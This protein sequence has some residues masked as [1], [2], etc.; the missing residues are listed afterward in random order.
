[1]LQRRTKVQHATTRRGFGRALAVATKEATDKVKHFKV[2]LLQGLAPALLTTPGLAA[3][4]KAPPQADSLRG[5]F[6]LVRNS[7]QKILTRLNS[8]K[9]HCAHTQHEF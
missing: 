9:S 6:T 4:H 2:N 8:E 3:R 7:P 5:C 1:M